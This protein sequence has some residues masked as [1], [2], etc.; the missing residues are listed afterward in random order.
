MLDFWKAQ[1]SQTYAEAKTAYHPIQYP[2]TDAPVWSAVRSILQRPWFS[3]VW[4]FQEIVLAKKAVLCCGAH[5]L[6]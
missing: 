6:S 5:T 1:K 3:R 2:A 4:T